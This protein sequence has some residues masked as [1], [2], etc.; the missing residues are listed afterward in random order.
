MQAKLKI[1]QQSISYWERR[2]SENQRVVS[3]QT[4]GMNMNT[5]STT[6]S[7][8][9]PGMPLINTNAIR[10]ANGQ[11]ITT[12]NKVPRLSQCVRPT[13]KVSNTNQPL[14]SGK[15]GNSTYLNK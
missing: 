9:S 11:I 3:H 13:P 12:N 15:I 8:T 5:S 4:N 10:L 2:V 14:V 7:S 6:N 1:V